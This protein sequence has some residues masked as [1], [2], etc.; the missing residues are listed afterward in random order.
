[1]IHPRLRNPSTARDTLIAA[2]QSRVDPAIK[3]VLDV[4][5]GRATND[6]LTGDDWV[7]AIKTA[8]GDIAVHFELPVDLEWWISYDAE[9]EPPENGYAD[10]PFYQWTRHPGSS[11]WDFK[12]N[13]AGILAQSIDDMEGHEY[14]IYRSKIV[15]VSDAPDWLQEKLAEGE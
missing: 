8:G 1:V 14:D 4:L 2:T 6:D 7:T 9:Y 13:T 15:Q 12:R 3:P 10:G 11:G 5:D